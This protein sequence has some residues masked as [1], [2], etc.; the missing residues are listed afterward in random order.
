MRRLGPASEGTRRLAPLAV[1]HL[2]IQVH[3]NDD[4]APILD[5]VAA[6][7]RLF[8]PRGRFNRQQGETGFWAAV[9]C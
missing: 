2:H 1:L 4:P 9:S 3:V 5:K 8:P 7:S 6:A